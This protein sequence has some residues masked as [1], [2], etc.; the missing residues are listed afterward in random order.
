VT[1]LVFF[2]HVICLCCRCSRN[3]GDG[4]CALEKDCLHARNGA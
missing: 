1:K 4:S 3:C 2:C